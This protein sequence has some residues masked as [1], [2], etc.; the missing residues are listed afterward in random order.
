M[1]PLALAC[2]KRTS[3]ERTEGA[4]ACSMIPERYTCECAGRIEPAREGDQPI[5]CGRVRTVCV[6]SVTRDRI[7]ADPNVLWDTGGERQK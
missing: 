4:S 1:A 3:C 6:G 5:A 2:V 7:P